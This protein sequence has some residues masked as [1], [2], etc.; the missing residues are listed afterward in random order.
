VNPI[1]MR[2]VEVQLL[3]EDGTAPELSEV[4]R[5]GA[6]E[7]ERLDNLIA[8][9]PNKKAA[10]QRK[11]PTHVCVKCGALW[12]EYL[13]GELP[14]MPPPLADGSWSLW[15]KTCEPCCDNPPAEVFIG[16]LLKVR[17]RA[18]SDASDEPAR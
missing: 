16:N 18:T 5:I 10:P 2:M 11:D 17:P 15:S 13:A 1:A 4:C 9:M 7:I 8:H 3:F 12:I 14:N 6:N